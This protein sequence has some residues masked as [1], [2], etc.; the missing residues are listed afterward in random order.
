[1][2]RSR[3]TIKWSSSWTVQL[4]YFCHFFIGCISETI[5][6]YLL[7]W[8]LLFSFVSFADRTMRNTK[9]KL[10]FVICFIFHNQN[11]PIFFFRLFITSFM[12]FCL[13]QIY[14]FVHLCTTE[15]WLKYRYTAPLRS[16]CF[17]F[18]VYFFLCTH[19]RLKAH[20]YTAKSSHSW[21][22]WRYTT[23]RHSRN[24]NYYIIPQMNI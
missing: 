11:H 6:G 23:G 4:E 1:M 3:N 7:C 19:T 16:G 22:I 20:L 9:K 15:K 24:E 18:L 2:L 10:Q 14:V 8:I 13:G 17:N 21:N 12:F 5:V